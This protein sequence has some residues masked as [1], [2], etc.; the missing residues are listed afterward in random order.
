MQRRFQNT[1]FAYLQEGGPRRRKK[2]EKECPLYGDELGRN[3]WSFLHTT[4]AYY[5]DNP[6]Q[7]QQTEMKQFIHLFSK[8]YP[9]EYCAEDLRE[10]W[11]NHNVYNCLLL[12]SFLKE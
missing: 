1:T 5:P 3:T 11:V 9:C 6:S 7:T 2:P 4:A 12:N 10:K 8:F